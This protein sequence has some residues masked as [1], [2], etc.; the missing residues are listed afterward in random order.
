MADTSFLERVQGVILESMGGGALSE[1][2]DDV[3]WRLGR[4]LRDIA[5]DAMVARQH[6]RYGIVMAAAN[7]I[8]KQLQARRKAN[9]RINTEVVAMLESLREEAEGA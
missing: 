2:P 8:G 6:R 1:Q 9:H 4:Q 5:K 3:L 7:M